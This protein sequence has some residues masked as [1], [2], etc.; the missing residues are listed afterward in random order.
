[1]LVVK[2]GHRVGCMIVSLNDENPS[3]FLLKLTKKYVLTKLTVTEGKDLFF[4]IVEHARAAQLRVVF[5]S[6]MDGL[7]SG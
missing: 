6:A 4:N 7:S 1:M 5:A 2:L 3:E